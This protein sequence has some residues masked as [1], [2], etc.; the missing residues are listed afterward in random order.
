MIALAR[1]DDAEAVALLERYAE[2]LGVGLS[3]AINAFEPELIVIG[4]GLSAAADLFL[5][6]AWEEAARRALPALFEDVRLAV[7]RAGAEAGVIGAG[8]MAAQEIER[9]RDTAG[10]TASEGVR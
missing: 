7:A 3:N 2:N 1:E 10:L 4:G 6:R 5:D 9:T 8:L